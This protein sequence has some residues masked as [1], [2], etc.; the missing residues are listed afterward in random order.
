[1]PIK[2]LITAM[3]L[4]AIAAV[5]A[6]AGDDTEW[7]NLR[8][9]KSGVRIGIVQPDG[10][11]TEGVFASFSD[12]SISLLAGQAITVPKDRVIRVYR[13]PRISRGLRAVLGAGIGGGLGALLNGTIGQYLRNE[14][15][16]VDAGVWIG[17][18]AGIGAG[19]GAASGGGERTVYRRSTHP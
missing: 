13:R 7:N 2:H 12:S 16:G 10:K 15:H 19:I 4:A 6:F 17:A 3:L 11:R 8:T 18:G 1:M 14:A 5:P 9:L